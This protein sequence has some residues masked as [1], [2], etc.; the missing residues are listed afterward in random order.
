[1]LKSTYCGT[2]SKADLLPPLAHLFRAC[3]VRLKKA[4]R[5][6]KNFLSDGARTFS[7]AFAETTWDIFTAH[8]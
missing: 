2:P 3:W 5:A 1:M 8:L 6:Y 7:A 4:V